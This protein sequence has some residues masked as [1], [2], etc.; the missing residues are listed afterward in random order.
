VAA[1]ANGGGKAARLRHQTVSTARR[2]RK[3]RRHGGAHAA[4]R[5]SRCARIAALPSLRRLGS[6]ALARCAL[7]CAHRAPRARSTHAH[8]AAQ[9]CA[10]AA[11]TA[12]AALH[13]VARGSC[14]YCARGVSTGAYK[15]GKQ[16]HRCAAAAAA[17]LRTRV[18]CAAKSAGTTSLRRGWRIRYAAGG[19]ASRGKIGAVAQRAPRRGAAAS[20]LFAKICVHR[21][22]ISVAA[23]SAARRN[24]AR[25]RIRRRA[26][27]LRQRHGEMARSCG[28]AT[29]AATKLARRRKSAASRHAWRAHQR[30]RNKHP[31]SAAGAKRGGAAR[32]RISVGAQN[33][34]V[35]AKRG[36]GMAARRIVKSSSTR[37]IRAACCSARSGCGIAPVTTGA[38]GGAYRRI[39][40][41]WRRRRLNRRGCKSGGVAYKREKNRRGAAHRRAQNAAHAAWPHGCVRGG[42]I[43]GAQ[44]H[45]LSALPHRRGI[46]IVNH[47]AFAAR[48]RQAALRAGDKT[49]A[50]ASAAS[51]GSGLGVLKTSNAA[52]AN[53][54]RSGISGSVCCDGISARR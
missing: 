38:A 10:G 39:S 44:A 17:A 7:R 1:A 48:N 51:R 21:R 22:G 23:A 36:G 27:R 18:T 53:A 31:A 2:R 24:V 28:S 20:S 13:G 35:S 6:R 26:R 12:T 4:L 3:R 52:T 29:A 46:L 40:R 37:S 49:S 5:R 15:C 54:A 30:R 11:S 43:A 34:I 19:N 50:R 41:R 32:R 42:A 47:A 8:G 16:R 9:S 25:R 14:A 33:G 45:H